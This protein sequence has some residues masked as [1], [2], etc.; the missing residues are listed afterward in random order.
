MSYT[1]VWTTEAYNSF[2]ERLFYLETH[3]TDRELTNFKN[4]VKEYLNILKEE[5]L[6]GKKPG[7]LKTFI[8]GL[9]SNRSL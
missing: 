2:E 1:I 9:F 7:N 4:R 3:W 6:I 5:P 8:W